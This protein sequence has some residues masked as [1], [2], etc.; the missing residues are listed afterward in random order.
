MYTILATDCG[1]VVFENGGVL[2]MPNTFTNE[3]HADM[4]FKYDFCT[5]NGRAAVVEY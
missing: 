3:E 2:K 1:C 5:I 4:H